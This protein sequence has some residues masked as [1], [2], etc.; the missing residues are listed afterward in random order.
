MNKFKIVIAVPVYN[1]NIRAVKT[2]NQILQQTKNKIIII[3]D[4][5]RDQ[6]F[7]LLAANFK[8]NK[9]IRL[10]QN[11]INLGKGESMTIA[12]ELSWKEGADAVI[13][14]DGDGQH[15]PKFI[16]QFEKLIKQSA[17]VF[18]YRELKKDVP[19]IRKW[20]NY[21][22]KKLVQLLFNIK[23]RDLLCGYFAITKKIYPAIEWHSKHYGVETEIAT[24]VGKLK[25]DFKEIKVNTTYI[26]KYKGV[27]LLDAL[28]I[29]FKI[30]EW[31]FFS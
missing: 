31:Y 28:K 29:L 21:L 22:A 5:S 25:L 15:D 20:G 11:V 24:K 30:P 3:D 13:F 8:N 27:N 4:G 26:D 23:R 1:E 16:P 9:Q 7:K 10:H 12:L 18:G 2:I 14:L 19:L 6:T 17:M